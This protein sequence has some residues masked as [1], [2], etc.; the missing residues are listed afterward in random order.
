MFIHLKD[1]AFRNLDFP[2]FCAIFSNKV[3]ENSNEYF[4]QKF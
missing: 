3:A 4:V 1:I 2:P